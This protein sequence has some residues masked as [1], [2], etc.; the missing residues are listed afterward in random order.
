VIVSKLQ[1]VDLAG[2]ERMVVTEYDSKLMKECIEI[3]KSLFTLRKVITTLNEVQTTNKTLY[4]PY[5]ESKLTSLLRESIG[6]NSYSLMIAGLSPSDKHIDENISTLNYATK[7]AYISN[8]PIKNQDP[9]TKVIL[10]LR[11]LVIYKY[12]KKLKS[13]HLN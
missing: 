3:N 10:Q 11:V 8:M 12:R 13:L 1:L 9:K 7:A 5:R 2:S 4:V 6:G